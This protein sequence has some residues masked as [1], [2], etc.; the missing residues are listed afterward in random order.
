[1]RNGPYELIRAPEGYP[2]KRYR[3]KYA[4]EHI[5]VFWQT[6]GRMPKDGYLVHHQN[7]QKRDN[8]PD[9]LEEKTVQSH[10]A[11]H[12]AVAPV[13][14]EC[15]FCK[16]PFELKPSIYRD[17]LRGSVSGLVFCSRS[18]GTKYQMVMGTHVG[19]PFR[20]KLPRAHGM[21]AM[22][23]DGC[24]CQEC[25]TANTQRVLKSRHKCKLFRDGLTGK[26]APC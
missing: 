26:S 15:G 8:R 1:M 16:V 5:V 2:G 9:N 11:D 12:N 18:H 14:V 25:K 22:Y 13:Q 4:Y 7:D 20:T 3:G 19:T 21:Y 6:H 24:R 23:R 17:R 10:N